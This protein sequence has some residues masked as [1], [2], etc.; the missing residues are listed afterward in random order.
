MALNPKPSW[1]RIRKEI[2]E[3]RRVVLAVSGGADSMFLLDFAR[4]SNVDFT[5][6]HF[7]H[8][9]RS[10]SQ[11]DCEHVRVF[12]ESIGAR[13]VTGV[14]EGIHN[15]ATAR[16]QR[17][18]FLSSVLAETGSTRVL[19]GHHY[20][21]Q[22]ETVFLRLIRGYPHHALKMRRDN[23]L[24]F[25]PFIDVRRSDILLECEKRKIPFIHDESN[26]DVTI[27]RNRL[28]HMVIPELSKIRNIHAAMATQLVD[29]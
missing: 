4:R 5:V 29:S 23:G 14:G 6:A 10:S 8:R 25:R 17:Y 11:K 24:V 1:R 12:C 19:T 9:M 27:E 22:I 13:F 16:E 18:A 15:E 21:D 2:E 28:R 20:D 3:L 7:D 26:D